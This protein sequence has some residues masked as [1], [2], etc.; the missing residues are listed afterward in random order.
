MR[1]AVIKIENSKGIRLP[2]VVLEKYAIE[3]ALD[4][5]MEDD[6][7]FLR[8]V[9]PVRAGWEEAFQRMHEAGDDALLMDDVFDDENLDEL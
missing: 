6:G 9:K 4:I 3:D 7:I 2:K 1:L 8:P 5:V